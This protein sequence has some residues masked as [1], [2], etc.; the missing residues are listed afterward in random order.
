MKQII[1]SVM[2]LMS[3]EQ[4]FA[5]SNVK[6]PESYNYQRGIEAV[7]QEKMGEALGRT[8]TFPW[9]VHKDLA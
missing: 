2:L 7:Q 8:R 6:R 1:I 3:I 9:Q 4:M 5:Q